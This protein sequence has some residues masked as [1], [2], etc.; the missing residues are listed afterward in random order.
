MVARQGRMD[1]WSDETL[2]VTAGLYIAALFWPKVHVLKA[3]PHVLHL[4]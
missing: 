4:Y 3:R 1:Q 2:L